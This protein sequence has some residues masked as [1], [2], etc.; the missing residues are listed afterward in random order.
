[1]KYL[2]TWTLSPANY[3]A[4]TE[5][6]LQTGGG[7][8]QGVRIIGRYHA[9]GHGVVIAEG[10]VKGIYQWIA[11][12]SDL[13]AFTVTPVMEDAEAAEVMRSAAS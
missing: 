3:K 11:Q 10:D 4:A 2:V 13:L 7:A 12:W 5:R 9:I 8:P 6:F 1:V